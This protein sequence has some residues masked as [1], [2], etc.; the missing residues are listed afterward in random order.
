MSVNKRDRD[1]ISG[2]T[3]LRFFAAFFILFAHLSHN[4]TINIGPLKYNLGAISAIGMPLF[5]ILSG[6]VIHYNYSVIFASRSFGSACGLFASHRVARIFPLFLAVLAFHLFHDD[7]YRLWSAQ[8]MGKVLYP[9]YILGF[10]SWVPVW[11]DGKLLIQQNFGVSWSIST[12]LFFYVTY[13]F[14]ARHLFQANLRASLINLIR[15]IVIAYLLM[16]VAIR[17]PYTFWASLFPSAPLDWMNSFLR[18]LFYVSPYGRI[19]EFLA[20]ALAAQAVMCIDPSPK[21]Q[22]W[23]RIGM[24]VAL[25]VILF[26]FVDFVYL[27]N[28]YPDWITNTAMPKFHRFFI[29]ASMNFLFAPAIVLLILSISIVEIGGGTTFFS[30][31]NFVFLG[32][33][34]YS[35]YLIHP[36]SIR[37]VPVS[38]GT[39]HIWFRLIVGVVLTIA[40]A[41]GT[42]ALIEVPGRKYFRKVLQ[43]LFTG[44]WRR[45]FRPVAS[46]LADGSAHASRV[47][48]DEKQADDYSKR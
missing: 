16:F 45:F 3:G 42:H 14:Y 17:V 1:N 41:I 30:W 9:A 22:K 2:L 35:L 32:E 5:F 46:E 38:A 33:I 34:S 8:N 44:D 31:R 13:V 28:R 24:W 40:L 15:V 19:F 11:L 29:Y 6:F 27:V 4:V 21:L 26:Q 25:S 47:H 10:F 23:A 48:M 36:I 39:P 7:M 43:P 20:G 12:E 37:L 18:W